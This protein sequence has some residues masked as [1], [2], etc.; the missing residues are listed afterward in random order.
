MT[1]FV[2]TSVWSLAWR[3]DAPPDLPEVS[4]LLAAL[5]AMEPIFATGLVLHELLQGFAGPVARSRILER[6]SAVP[7]VRPDLRD[8]VDAADLHGA[9]RRQGV[10]AS[11]IDVLLAQLCIRREL[12]M[13]SADRDFRHIARHSALQLW[14]PDSA[15]H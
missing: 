4:R 9:L 5:D 11:T 7:L 3:R 2:D 13:L 14:S 15:Q 12:T 1:L 10:Q 8:H 6:F